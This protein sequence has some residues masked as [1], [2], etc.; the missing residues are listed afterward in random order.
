V[1]WFPYL[2][3]PDRYAD[4]LAAM[5]REAMERGRDP[6]SIER[7]FLVFVGLTDPAASAVSAA[8][9]PPERR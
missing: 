8:S 6:D 4:G 5:Q 9:N 1:G 3:T 7:A 2:M